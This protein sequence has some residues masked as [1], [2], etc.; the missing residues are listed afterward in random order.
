MIYHFITREFLNLFRAVRVGQGKENSV[1]KKFSV[2]SEG[3]AEGGCGGNSASP[4]PKRSP[5]ALL[6]QSRSQQKSFLFLL[7][8]KSR[9]AKIRKAEKTFLLAG[10]RQRAAAGRSG[11]FRSAILDKMSSSR[12][13]KT[14]GL[15]RRQLFARGT[16]TPSRLPPR[17]A[18]RTFPWYTC[19]SK[20]LVVRL[21]GRAVDPVAATRFITVYRRNTQPPFRMALKHMTPVIGGAVAAVIALAIGLIGLAAGLST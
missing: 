15:G 13:V 8:E 9:R 4:E 5:A 2:G 12:V 20:V 14:H 10:E 11:W 3:E 18:R 17:V 6:V 21:G 19:T 16:R 7:E 1:A